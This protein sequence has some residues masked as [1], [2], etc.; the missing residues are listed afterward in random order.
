MNLNSQ[1]KIMY[2]KII[3]PIKKLVTG[4]EPSSKIFKV[5][6]ENLKSSNDLDLK[7]NN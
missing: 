3:K 4:F 5:S 2:S 7:N 1:L 6:E